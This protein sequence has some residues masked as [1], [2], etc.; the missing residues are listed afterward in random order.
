MARHRCAGYRLSRARVLRGVS[1]LS[2]DDRS[3]PDS[4]QTLFSAGDP[5]TYA[6]EASYTRDGELQR[7]ERATVAEDG[8]ALVRHTSPELTTEWYQPPNATAHHLIRY[9]VADGAAIEAVLP[10]DDIETDA[11]QSVLDVDRDAG[12]ALVRA[13]GSIVDGRLTE[14]GGTIV[15]S[16]LDR[17]SYDRT[18]ESESQ[19]VYEPKNG[20]YDALQE[21]R[22]TGA[23]GEVH[24]DTDTERVSSADVS[25][26]E[27]RPAD[28]YLRY[29]LARLAGGDESVSFSLDYDLAV[30]AV[31]LD[32]PEWA[33]P[34]RANE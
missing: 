28:P 23:S 11:A 24:V 34:L 22:V 5:D 20:W 14:P 32:E 30:D 15:L 4:A 16:G 19:T 25:W 18:G 29:A 1:V 27:T 13:N 26:T 8:A 17:M 21:Y 2:L 10:L 3:G 33:G 31:T 6:Y 9:T 7:E 12:T